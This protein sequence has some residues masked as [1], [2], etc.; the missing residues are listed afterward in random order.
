MQRHLRTG[1]GGLQNSP[2]TSRAG[3]N[4]RLILEIIPEVSRLVGVETN[5]S[6]LTLWLATGALAMS[7]GYQIPEVVGLLANVGE[8]KRKAT[9]ASAQQH[10]FV[11]ASYSTASTTTVDSL[12]QSIRAVDPR[13]T[14]SSSAQR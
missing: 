12:A 14:I 11:D 3:K 10:P 4:R 8:S 5:M 13:M 7:P 6:T 9:T 1:R 2:A